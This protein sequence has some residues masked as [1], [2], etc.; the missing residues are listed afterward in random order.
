MGPAQPGPPRP[1]RP[2]PPPGRPPRV[3]LPRPPPRP[4]LGPPAEAA[5]EQG[6]LAGEEQQVEA[7]AAAAPEEEAPAPPGDFSGAYCPPDRQP[8][9][10][11][12]RRLVGK[13]T[14]QRQ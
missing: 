2:R 10:R 4:P 13:Q 14:Q 11:V 5:P 8:D 3:L 6:Q 12:R 7:A 9:R 1:L